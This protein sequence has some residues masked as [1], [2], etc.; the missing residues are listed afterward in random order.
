MFQSNERI[1]IRN[2]IDD[3]VF[4]ITKPKDLDSILEVMK[5]EGMGM[6]ALKQKKVRIL[7]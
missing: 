4:E 2:Q 6:K 5:Q 7:K 1:Y 3:A